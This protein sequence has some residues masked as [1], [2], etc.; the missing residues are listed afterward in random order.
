MTMFIPDGRYVAL[1]H[2]Y[3][4]NLISQSKRNAFYDHAFLLR[5]LGS[6]TAVNLVNL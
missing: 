4:Q 5:Y 6:I 2:P 1:F 3:Q